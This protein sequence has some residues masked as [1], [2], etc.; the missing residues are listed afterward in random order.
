MA[1]LKVK[2]RPEASRE[3]A[4]ALEWY[5][6]RDPRVGERFGDVYIK[7]LDEAATKPGRWPKHRDGT[8]HIQLH[9]FPYLLI[10]RE[11]G[12][13]LQVVAVSHTSRR[14]RYWRN[15]LRDQ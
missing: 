4:E 3:L 6:E 7:K 15:R 1:S 11:L 2:Y 5:G 13:V 8:R 14:P 12:D 10:V 9:P